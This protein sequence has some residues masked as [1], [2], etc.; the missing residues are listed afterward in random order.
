MRFPHLWIS[1]WPLPHYCSSATQLCPTLCDPMDCSTPGF[2]VFTISWSLLKLMSIEPV[3]P[4][5]HLTLCWPLFLLPLIFPSIRVFS[6]DPLPQ[7]GN[8]LPTVTFPWIKIYTEFKEKKKKVICKFRYI[9]CNKCFIVFIRGFVM[10]Q[11][12]IICVFIY[13]MG[14]LIA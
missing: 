2:S 10:V 6:N 12:L 3:M 11:H 1:P 8:I 14:P 9:K 13:Y 5:N 7:R 4:S